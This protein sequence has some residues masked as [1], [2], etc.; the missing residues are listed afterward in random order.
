MSDN[1]CL[2]G[3]PAE[4]HGVGEGN[5]CLCC[6]QQIQEDGTCVVCKWDY[7]VKNIPDGGTGD[8][9]QLMPHGRP[10]ETAD[11]MNAA[12]Y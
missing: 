2:R 1:P 8:R 5:I 3:E 12:A 6:G 9:D 11:T 4:S 7:G 10:I